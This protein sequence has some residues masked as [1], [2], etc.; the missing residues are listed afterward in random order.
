MDGASLEQRMTPV[1]LLAWIHARGISGVTTDSK[2]DHAQLD[3]EVMTF[4]AILHRKVQNV[5]GFR[6]AWNKQAEALETGPYEDPDFNPEA[7]T[8]ATWRLTRRVE[9]FRILMDAAVDAKL[10]D[11][12]ELPTDTWED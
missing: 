4:Y 11:V 1:G 10:F 2:S 9:Q 5:E 8:E 3:L 6:D 12:R 7:M